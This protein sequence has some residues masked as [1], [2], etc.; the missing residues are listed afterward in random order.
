MGFHWFSFEQWGQEIV[1]AMERI[2][3]MWVAKSMMEDG[4]IATDLQEEFKIIMNEE[5]APDKKTGSK[6]TGVQKKNICKNKPASGI[7]KKRMDKKLLLAMAAQGCRKMTSWIMMSTP[8]DPVTINRR[9]EASRK[10][11]AWLTKRMVEELLLETVDMTPTVSVAG[12]LIDVLVERSWA[13]YKKKSA[14]SLLEKDK[15]LQ[16]TIIR[17]IQEEEAEARR[18]W[19]EQKT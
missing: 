18:V 11:D 4:M 3:D 12:G 1:K 10:K 15:D 9:T 16:K 19:L 7:K 5:I 6:L 17:M 8:D 2:D 14:W 13:E